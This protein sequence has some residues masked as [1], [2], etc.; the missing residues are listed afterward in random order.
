MEAQAYASTVTSG[1]LPETAKALV[2]LLGIDAT[3]ALVGDFGG[4]TL[5]IPIGAK[6]QGKALLDTISKSVGVEGAIK[7][8]ERYGATNLYV[9]NCKPALLKAR[10]RQMLEERNT[11]SK[12]GLGERAI[13]AQ[14]SLK[15]K[16]SD[17][18]VWGILSKPI[19]KASGS[20]LTQFRLC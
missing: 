13:V 9:P 14:L 16:L 3:L 15:Y 7:I 20:A 11:L 2:E 17:R 6:E 5:R 8:M 12:E 18:A 10:N 19:E 4:I 1:D